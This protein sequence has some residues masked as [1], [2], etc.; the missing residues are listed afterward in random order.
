MAT[1]KKDI[2]SV[3]LELNEN[4]LKY[5]RS[6]EYATL[7]GLGITSPELRAWQKNPLFRTIE[8][9]TKEG[10]PVTCGNFEA[11][12]PAICAGLL[13]HLGYTY[14][15]IENR[16]ELERGI[17]LQ[18]LD[19]DVEN[20]EEYDE[21]E[22]GTPYDGDVFTS[23]QNAASDTDPK[24]EKI[25]KEYEAEKH[26]ITEKQSLAIPLMLA[27]KN[28]QEVGDVIGVSRYTIISWRKDAAFADELHEARTLLRESQLHELSATISKA[29]KVVEEMLDH[30]D[31]QVR[32]KAALGL[33][34]GTNFRPPEIPKHRHWSG[35]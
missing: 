11:Y 8:A 35:Y 3:D 22:D 12:L 18:W 25:R 16:L 13:V 2:A 1:R 10:N 7:E 21:N 31:P 15:D 17:L 30:K 27:G 4:Q 34:K 14:V 26:E 20:E 24:I 33:L 6:N 5:L 28:D 23:A 32:L 29:F 19:E 9:L